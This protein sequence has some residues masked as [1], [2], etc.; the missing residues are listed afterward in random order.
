[1]SLVNAVLSL[2]PVEVDLRIA[3]ALGVALVQSVERFDSFADEGRELR[4]PR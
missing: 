3:R 4:D 2:P 1:M